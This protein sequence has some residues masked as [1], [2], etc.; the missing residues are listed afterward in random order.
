MVEIVTVVEGC[1]S[2][3]DDGGDGC[4]GDDGDGDCSGDGG[5]GRL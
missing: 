4:S 1:S 2:D 5:G 3:D